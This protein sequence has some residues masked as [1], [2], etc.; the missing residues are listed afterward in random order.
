MLLIVAFGYGVLTSTI[1]GI[2]TFNVTTYLLEEHTRHVQIEN[3]N[4]RKQK[5]DNKIKEYRIRQIQHNNLVRKQR[6]KETLNKLDQLSD[7]IEERS[8]SLPIVK[9]RS[10]DDLILIKSSNEM[11]NSYKEKLWWE[12]NDFNHFMNDHLVSDEYFY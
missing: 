7:D 2:F 5:N 11:S 8:R 6:N 3:E 12:Q 1:S 9:F 10:R 4:L